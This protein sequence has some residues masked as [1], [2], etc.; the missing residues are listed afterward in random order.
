VLAVLR[1]DVTL[2][3]AARRAETTEESVSTWRQ[4]FVEGGKAALAGSA[5][6]DAIATEGAP[7]HEKAQWER[8]L[9][10][11]YVLAIDSQAE[12]FIELKQKLAY[13]LITASA[14]VTGFVTKFAI[15]HLRVGQHFT[16]TG[17]QTALL[18]ASALTGAAAAGC[19][20]LSIRSEHHSHRLHLEY[21][22]GERDVESLTAAETE[23]WDALNERAASLFR[24]AGALLFLEIGLAVAFFIAVFV[25]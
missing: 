8:E 6:V 7:A 21:R 11:A 15:D 17:L 10:Q 13:F 19:S 16:G 4:Q 9:A 23:S 1:G 12:K 3:Q 14:V 20:L 22:Y 5:P 25:Q 18:V 2:A 24:S